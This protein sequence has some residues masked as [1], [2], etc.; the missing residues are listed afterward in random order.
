[1]WG[2]QTGIG[3]CIH[4]VC[5]EGVELLYIEWKE[6][7]GGGGNQGGED[8]EEETRA[9]ACAEGEDGGG[10]E[11]CG[12]GGL[13]AQGENTL[14]LHRGEDIAQQGVLQG[15]TGRRDHIQ[16][17]YLQSGS[18]SWHMFCVWK[19]SIHRK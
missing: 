16:I 5:E 15:E 8:E 7:Q 19:D 12:T 9:V 10:Y 13:G 14:Y 2:N 6:S 3:V 1:M 18:E 17:V 11:V 4:E